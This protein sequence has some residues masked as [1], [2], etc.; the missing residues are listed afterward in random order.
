M[1]SLDAIEKNMASVNHKIGLLINQLRDI[2]HTEI[3]EGSDRTPN[4]KAV[5]KK[6]AELEKEQK[7]LANEWFLTYEQ[8]IRGSYYEK[9]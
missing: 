5:L 8:Q 6:K 2:R 9:I 1:R 4:R 7:M 3:W